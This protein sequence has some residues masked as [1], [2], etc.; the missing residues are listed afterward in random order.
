VDP[1]DLVAFSGAPGHVR[2]VFVEGE[3][4]VEDGRLAHLNLATIRAEADR[5]CQA[6]LD[7][8]GLSF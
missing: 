5:A 2:Y 1:H 6:L 3:Q 7:R 4:L 8:C